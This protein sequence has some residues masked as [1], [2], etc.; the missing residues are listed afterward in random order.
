MAKIIDIEGIGP[1]NAAKLATA[2]ITTTGQLLKA[3][4][5]ASGRSGLSA[6][7]G[8]STAQLLEW[9]NRCDLFRVKGVATQYSDLLE[10][11]GVDSPTEL[12][13][14]NAENLQAKIAEVNAARKLVRQVPSLKQVE[15]M[16]ASAKGLA[17]VVTH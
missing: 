9:V 12:A 1:A 13:A 11:A 17:K 5:S 14:R 2:G 7:T 15:A 4:A 10:A 6:K 16:V 3:G 8:V